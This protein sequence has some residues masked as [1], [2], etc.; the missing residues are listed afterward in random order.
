LLK[1]KINISINDFI[2]FKGK[3]FLTIIFI[4]NSYLIFA[5]TGTP[6]DTTQSTYTTVTEIAIDSLALL[7]HAN[8]TIQNDT[9]VKSIVSPDAVDYIIDYSCEDSMMFSMTQKKMYL[10]GTGT[11][12]TPEMNLK[13][14]YV[15]INT[16]ENY[17]FARG[18]PDSTGHVVGK[19]VFK[20]GSNEFDAKSI[21]YNFQTRKGIVR[22]VLTE[23]SQGFLHGGVSKIHENKEIHLSDGKY[24]T[25]NLD[26]PHFYI[27]LT[28]AKVIPDKRIVS[29]PMYFVIA[30]IPLYFIGLPFGLIPSQNNNTSGILIPKYGEEQKR[31]FFLS[32]GGYFWAIND[33]LNSALTFDLF[34]KGSWGTNL[35][36]NFKKKY[37][38]SGN[39]DIKYSQNRNGEK[40]LPNFTKS[41]TFWVSGA[42]AQD[43]KANPNSNFSMSL[44]FGSS[45]HNAFN[46]IDIEQF[47]TTTTSSSVAYQYQKPGSIFNFSANA[48]YTQ[49]TSTHVVNLTLPTISYNMRRIY[50]LENLGTGSKWYKKIGVSMSSSFKNSVTTLDSTFLSKET[51][52]S[53]E[54]MSKM[55]NGFRYTV[56]VSTSFKMLKYFNV[57]PSFTYNGRIYTDYIEKREISLIDNQD[58]LYQ[59]F[60]RDTING[61]KH[62]FDFNFSLPVSTKLFGLYK[63]KRSKISAIRHVV[64]PSISFNYRPDF[65][66][67]LWGYYGQYYEDRTD[68]L[69]SYFEQGLFGYPPAGKSGSI[70]FS[71]GNNIE[72]KVKEKTDSTDTFKKIKLLNNF[73]VSTSYNI[74]ADS[75][76]WSYI[77]TR[78]NTSLFKTINLNFNASFDTYIRDSLNRRVNTFEIDENGRLARLVSAGVSTSGSLNSKKVAKSKDKRS[79]TPFYFPNTEIAY[80]AFDVPWDVNI[81]YNFTVKN[82][83][84]TASQE[85]Q[86]S[87]TQTVSL[88]ANLSLTTNWR[89][90]ARSDYDFSAQKFTYS[91]ISLYR[92]LHCWEMSLFIIPYGY[93]KSYNFRINI[94]SSVFQG[95]EYKKQKSWHDNF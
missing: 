76:N 74:A 77:V 48:N 44:N 52:L 22:D 49:N 34:S 36:M 13:A 16:N 86:K 69:Y 35:K 37:K 4:F 23:H 32:N 95:L 42:L 43:A 51:G 90:T 79:E 92:D 64:S 68:S 30:D 45:S 28:K 56:P 21:K 91:Q 12:N 66:R 61:I 39:F 20:Q 54:T 59:T 55:K 89:V 14:D 2:F 50:P 19:P 85:Y 46:A 25:C 58:S 71:L 70:G 11:I 81:S 78:G 93:L 17:I 3:Y 72:M 94:K 5:Q 57:S 82:I 47:A 60:T 33:N 31:G 53:I 84:N 26:H 8:D 27:E 73:G 65:S 24:T 10:Y 80:A 67:D 1:N 15:E 83:F 87:I 29:G 18:V 38:Y 6:A 75:L 7:K 88:R 63:F 41:N 62:P 40:I 9:V